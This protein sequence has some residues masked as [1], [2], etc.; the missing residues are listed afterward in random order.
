M[1]ECGSEFDIRHVCAVHH[2]EFIRESNGVVTVQLGHPNLMQQD[3]QSSLVT[4]LQQQGY[5]VTIES[6]S[7]TIGAPES[8]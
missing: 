4:L 1:S 2:C 7:S 8:G 6:Y 3:D 5:T